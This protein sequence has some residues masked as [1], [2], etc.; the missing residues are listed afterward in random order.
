M[1]RSLS[2]EGAE[3]IA[4]FEGFSARL[5]ND[6][7]GHCSIGFGH[8]VHQ[9]KCDG[10]EPQEFKD[11]ITRKK[12]IRM[13]RDDAKV[14]ADEINRSV[15]VPLKQTQ[16]DALVSFVFNVGTGAFRESTLLRRLNKGRYRDVPEQLDRWVFAGGK[17]L[18]SLVERRRAEGRLFREGKY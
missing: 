17:K 3:F 16:F 14:A 12:G 6:P 2:E 7:A 1:K 13:L 10:R 9:G 4:G 18:D 11:G 15:T 8:Q 5:Y